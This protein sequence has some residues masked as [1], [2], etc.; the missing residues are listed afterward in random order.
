MSL[1]AKLELRQSQT[2]VMTPQLQQA[3][4][5]LQ[6]SNLEL[7]AFVEAELERNP[8]LE[9]VEGDGDRFEA[10]AAEPA[11]EVESA[12]SLPGEVASTDEWASNAPGEAVQA[13]DAD[14]ASIDPEAS[15]AELAAPGLSSWGTGK[16]GSGGMVGDDY[17]LE[18]FVSE[19]RTLAD[20]L[21]DQLA[22]TIRDPIDRLIGEHLIDMV[23]EAGYLRGGLSEV[24]D[25]LGVPLAR[26]E[27]VLAMIQRFDPAGVA[28]RSV[29]ECLTIQLRER[30]RYDP[31]IASV[32]DNLHLLAS[33]DFASLRRACRLNQEDLADIIQEIRGLDAKPGLRFG[34]VSV[35]PVVP[36]VLVR[37]RQDGSWL[38]ELN[39]ETLPKVLVNQSYF[40]SVSRG[41]RNEDDRSYLTG[42]LQTASWL[43][44][45][46]DQRARTILKVSEEI[47]R[48]QD[49]FLTYGV[50][51]LRP[52]NLRTIA[53][54]IQMHESTVSRVTSN[55]YMATPRGIFEL[56]YFFTSAISSA[57]DGEA[58]SSESVRHRI[59]Q[60]IDAE[61]AENVLSDDKIV[62]LLRDG[63]IDIARRTV[64]KY[65]EGMS[66]PSSVQRRRMK[67]ITERTT[68]LAS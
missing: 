52:L 20:H 50:E 19:A 28:A 13:L 36:D 49:A 33:H 7:A 38:V 42:C 3:I 26:I 18:G 39:G 43:V 30:N 31:L 9:R 11:R 27:R 24:A 51:H 46:L 1:S 64:A 34:S 63:G 66:I 5:L 37:A 6:L 12:T 32:L 58:L 44:K 67:R 4:K 62:E 8:I 56:K 2:L 68:R 10:P 17:D 59:R 53:D 41:V 60:L 55:K 57:G 23:D 15:F 14:Y 16:S 48:Q 45:S 35:Q 22:A 25:Q 65:R 47:V 29:V 21:H 61:T 40:A 54:A